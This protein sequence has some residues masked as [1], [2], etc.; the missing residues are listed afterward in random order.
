L[1]QFL[2]EPIYAA[3]EEVSGRETSS[4]SA[5]LDMYQ[6]VLEC[7]FEAFPE[8]DQGKWYRQ[9]REIQDYRG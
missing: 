2:V 4:D 7:I 5:T 1:L 3:M 9:W 8:E 6:D